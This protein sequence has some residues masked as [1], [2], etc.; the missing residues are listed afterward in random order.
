MKPHSRNTHSPAVRALTVAA[1]SSTFVLGG[2][3]LSACGGGDDTSSTTTTSSV[4]VPSGQLSADKLAAEA[5]SLCTATNQQLKDGPAPPDFGEDGPQSDEMKAAAPYFQATADGQQQLYDQL[6]QLQPASDVA[7][8][9]Q[10]FL[11]SYETNVVEQSAA[12]ADLAAA[13]DQDKFFSTA[14]DGQAALQDLS[15]MSSG[16]GMKVCGASDTAASS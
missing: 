4:S 5:D 10:A 14:L 13:G 3:G 2:L 9:W 15:A 16:L 7:K 8:D 11:K 12:L 6:S 1:V